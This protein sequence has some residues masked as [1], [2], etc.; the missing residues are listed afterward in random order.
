MKPSLV[1]YGNC[2]AEWVA[3]GLQTIPTVADRFDI[4][5]VYSFDHP[6]S[7]LANPDLSLLGRCAV[8]LEQ[9]GAWDRF[10]WRTAVPASAQVVTFPALTM[11]ALWP[12]TTFSDP[13]NVPVLPDYP[14]GLFPY[15]DRLISDWVMNGVSRD[16]TLRRYLAWS[17]AESEDLARVMEMGQVRLE[18]ADE[19]CD[20]KMADAV[21][22]RL[23]HEPL[24]FTCNHPRPAL[25]AM[26][27]GRVLDHSGLTSGSVTAAAQSI[28]A[29]FED[30][31][32]NAN[33]QVPIHPDVAGAFGLAWY[34][35]DLRY[36]CYTLVNASYED[37]WRAYTWH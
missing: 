4:H 22:D 31:Q 19:Q 14:F 15:G 21:L 29:L 26:L 34:R 1:V 27:A 36:C 33:I 37:Y 7:G 2:Q 25:L 18:M 12:L 32:P 11:D 23:A 5:Y 28:R 3:L 16:E 24:F 13:R 6:V 30:R 9:R 20:V 35:T 10:R 17:L 8:L